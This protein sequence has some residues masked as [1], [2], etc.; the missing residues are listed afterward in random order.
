VPSCALK[1]KE[2]LKLGTPI[3]DE[4]KGAKASGSHV[5]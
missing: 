2:L 4:R 5:S 1:K 3:R